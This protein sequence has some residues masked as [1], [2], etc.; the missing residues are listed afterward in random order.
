MGVRVCAPSSWSQRRR[1]KL[2]TTATSCPLRDRY[3]AV[4]QPQ[5]PSPPNTA[6]FIATLLGKRAGRGPANAKSVVF[7]LPETPLRLQ[8][9][10]AQWSALALNGEKSNYLMPARG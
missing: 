2:S 3:K 10:V 5:Y 8:Q 7:R 4:A 6:I 1:A 9:T